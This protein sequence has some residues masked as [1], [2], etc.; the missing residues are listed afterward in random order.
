MQAA[1]GRGGRVH[2]GSDRHVRTK[3]ED[4]VE[5]RQTSKTAKKIDKASTIV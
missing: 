3:E 4:D 5:T 1:T 2:D